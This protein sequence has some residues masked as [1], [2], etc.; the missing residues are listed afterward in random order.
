MNAGDWIQVS[1]AFIA[2]ASVLIA[3]LNAIIMKGQLKQQQIQWEYSNKPAFRIVRSAKYIG[4]FKWI[5]IIE[6]TNNV[7]HQIN[8]ISF[9]SDEIELIRISHGVFT[10]SREDEKEVHKG[11]TLILDVKT[12]D[13]VVGNIKVEG[14]DLIGNS[15]K[16]ISPDIKFKRRDIID[17]GSFNHKYFRLI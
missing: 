1:L 10:S 3:M 12:G 7:F 16:A 8:E 14:I 9:S 11:L 2:M 17:S 15:F 6:N 13:F 4:D 5:L